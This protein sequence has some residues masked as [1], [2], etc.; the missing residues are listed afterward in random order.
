[1]G[2]TRNVYIIGCKI[3]KERLVFMLFDKVDGMNGVM[4]SAMFSSFQSAFPPPFINPMRLMPLTM[5]MSCPLL[6]CRLYSNSGLSLPVGSPG[7]F[8]V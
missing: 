6:G 4:E 2:K 1:M 5:D 7:K 8:L 3:H